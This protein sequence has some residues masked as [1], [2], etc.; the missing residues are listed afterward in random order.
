M[1]VITKPAKH[2]AP[3]P[4]LGFGLQSVRACFHLLTAPAGAK[5]SIEHADDVAVHY[6]DG[7][8]ELEQTKSALKQNPIADWAEDLWKTLAN[9]LDEV[10]SGRVSIRETRFRVYVSPAHTGSFATGL[11]NASTLADASALCAH[12]ETALKDRTK[13]PACIENVRRF[14]GTAASIRDRLICGIEVVSSDADPVDPI[15][16]LIKAAVS[17]AIVDTICEFG[18]GSAKEQV[19][20]L[21]RG[22]KPAVIDADEFKRKFRQFV[23][24]NNL[25]DFLLS[26]APKPDATQVH[27]LLRARPTFVR[28]LEIVGASD[29]FGVRAV[30]D[31]LRSAADRTKW[32]EAGTVYDETFQEWDDDL[33]R[34]HKFIRTEAAE[35]LAGLGAESIGRT[36]YSR[37][38]QLQMPLEGRV[39][40]SHFVHGSY[41]TLADQMRLGWH[42]DFE[43]LLN[44]AGD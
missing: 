23:R 35:T 27:T 13:P 34:R 4:Y 8:L 41:N 39:V 16:D 40:P 37:C 31:F 5:V 29:E 11:S 21:I 26:L 32:A 9:W 12:I 30:S 43:A 33:I 38:A 18:V 2:S 3:G 42:P 15:R 22:G 24:T 1:D 10:E 6:A 7:S 25:P 36:V 14:L 44:T 19:D 28:Q 17:P 20:R